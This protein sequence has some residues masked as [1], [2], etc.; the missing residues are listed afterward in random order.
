MTFPLGRTMQHTVRAASA[1]A[2]TR[3]AYAA[4]LRAAIAT[5]VPL[6][7]AQALGTGGATWMSLGGFNGALADRGGPYR[8]RAITMGAV[9]LCTA[10]C[11]ALGTVASG[12][13]AL[14]IPLTFVVALVASLARVWGTAGVSVGGATLTVFVIALAF[15]PT[16]GD[17]PLV[18][19]ALDVAGGLWA[20][21]IALV[22]WPLQPYRPARLALSASYPAPAVYPADVAPHPPAPLAPP[23]S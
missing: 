3:P 8:T 4:G 1:L 5:V 2:R 23:T 10:L 13:I 14:A 18:R 16:P 7:L 17:G 11:I 20:M 6:L 19:A 12:H 15:P 21:A 9:T 22:L